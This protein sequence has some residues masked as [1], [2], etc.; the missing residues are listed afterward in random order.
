MPL[1]ELT[2]TISAPIARCFDLARSIDLHK[3]S[4]EGT[5]EEA[6]AGV[7][8]GLIGYG[9]QVTWKARH[10][11][12]TQRLTSRITA[13]EYPFHFRDEMLQG[14]FKMIR[15]DHIFQEFFKE[16]IMIDRFEFESPGGALGEMFNRLVLEKYLLTLLVKR[17]KMIK[18][19]AESDLWKNILTN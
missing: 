12:L 16:T 14:A 10:F 17:N 9:E 1:I 18:D 19:V 5:E 3:L 2:T 11:G 13:F 7:T 6:I 8:S 4:T 15:H